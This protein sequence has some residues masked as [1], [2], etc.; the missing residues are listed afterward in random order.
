MKIFNLSKIEK[1]HL[2]RAWA[3]ISL[4]FAIVL[5][6]GLFKNNF[7]FFLILSAITIG[8][9]FLLHELAHKL[10]AQRYGCW[11]EFRAN[12][13]MLL[14]AIL[15]SFAGFVF[16][17]PGA[18]IIKGTV[19]TKRNGI[20]SLAGPAMNIALAGI[21]FGL[22]FIPIETISYISRYGMMINS[23]LAVF[24]LIPFGNIDGAKVIKWD[25]KAYFFALSLASFLLIVSLKWL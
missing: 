8:G 19:T 5:S 18:V 23:F 14:L 12:N 13:T 10:T 7:L 17:A 9:G 25:K 11:A 1:N 6:G 24:N 2:L 4:A 15:M 16:A 22:I 3:A 21:F 20:I